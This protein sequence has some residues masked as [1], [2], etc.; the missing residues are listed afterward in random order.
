MRFDQ[1][2][3]SDQKRYQDLQARLRRGEHL[4]T[5]DY[6]WVRQTSRETAY[7]LHLRNRRGRGFTRI[8]ARTARAQS[9]RKYADQNTVVK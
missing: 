5:A 7:A 1:L 6:A 8:L 3:E 4:E 9:T 2:S